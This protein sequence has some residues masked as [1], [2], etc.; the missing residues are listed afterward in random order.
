MKISFRLTDSKEWRRQNNYYLQLT[1]TT[2][3]LNRP[4]AHYFHDDKNNSQN[5]IKLMSKKMTWTC[6]CPWYNVKYKIEESV[7]LCTAW[8]GVFCCCLYSWNVQWHRAHTKFRSVR[9]TVPVHCFFVIWFQEI[10]LLENKAPKSKFSVFCCCLDRQLK[11]GIRLPKWPFFLASFSS[12][13]SYGFINKT[14][15]VWPFGDY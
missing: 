2:W 1:D 10:K 15:G 9:Y 13:C 3:Y 7:N 5:W 12:S 6:P 11:Y 14:K 4:A 8:L